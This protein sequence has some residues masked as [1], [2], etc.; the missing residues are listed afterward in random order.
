M[1]KYYRGGKN[2]KA[3]HTKTHTKPDEEGKLRII[4]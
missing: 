2:T 4:F 1:L 3:K